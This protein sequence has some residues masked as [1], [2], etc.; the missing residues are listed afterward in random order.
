MS[1]FGTASWA[2]MGGGMMGSGGWGM[3]EPEMMGPGMME[4]LWMQYVRYPQCTQFLDETKDLRKNLLIKRFEYFEAAR[5]PE[6]TSDALKLEE[7]IKQ[8]GFEIYQK[9]PFECRGGW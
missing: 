5:K 4:P 1:A 3:M 2:Q 8:L 6:T 9:A 7:E